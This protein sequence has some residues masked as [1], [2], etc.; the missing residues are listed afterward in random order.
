MIHQMLTNE[1]F[2]TTAGTKCPFPL[3][4]AVWARY[5]NMQPATRKKLAEKVKKEL[6]GIG[7]M[8]ENQKLCLCSPAGYFQ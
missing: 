5:Q 6:I 4:Q 1:D 8:Q 3:N 7:K 2:A